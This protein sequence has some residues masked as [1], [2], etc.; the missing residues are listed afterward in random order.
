MSDNQQNVFDAYAD[1]F[2]AGIVSGET[3]DAPKE[4]SA[5]KMAEAMWRCGC[6]VG[7]ALRLVDELG[8]E[9][10]K[11]ALETAYRFV[12]A[13]AANKRACSQ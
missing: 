7:N 1:Q 2:D 6:I 10:A 13:H 3:A 8:E 12:E 5:D 4:I 9:N 11:F